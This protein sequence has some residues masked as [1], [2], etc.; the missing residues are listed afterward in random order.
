MFAVG[1]AL[2]FVDI[3]VPSIHKL[4]NCSV[5][6]TAS[7]PLSNALLFLRLLKELLQGY[8]VALAIG[9]AFQRQFNETF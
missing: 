2:S 7:S 3:G 5:K 9:V 6:E 8:P 4:F 1:K